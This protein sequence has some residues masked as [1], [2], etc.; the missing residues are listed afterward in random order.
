MTVFPSPGGRLPPG[1]FH[2]E[3]GR[4]AGNGAGS[5]IYRLFIAITQKIL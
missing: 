4:R 2:A 3:N 1:L 5:K